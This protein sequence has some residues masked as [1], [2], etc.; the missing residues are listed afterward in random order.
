MALKLYGA[1]LSPCTSRVMTCLHEKEAD[2]EL[3]RRRTQASSFPSQECKHAPFGQ[4]PV[5]EDGD[6]SLFVR[7]PSSLYEQIF[8][9]EKKAISA[10]VAEKFKET[11]NDLIRHQ[12]LKEADEMEVESQQYHPTISPIIFEFLAAPLQGEA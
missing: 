10:Y 7:P 8:D 11:G 2:F 3:V 4:I 12:S 5:L 9:R 6:L 1:A